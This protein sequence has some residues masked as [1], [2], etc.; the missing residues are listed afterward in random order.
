MMQD[1][2]YAAPQQ[3]ERARRVLDQ[4][5]LERLGHGVKAGVDQHFLQLRKALEVGGV[6]GVD[7]SLRLLDRAPGLSRPDLLPVVAVPTIVGSVLGG[8]RHRRP[9]LHLGIDEAERCGMTP[10]MV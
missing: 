6:D 3:I 8:E 9:Q 7:L 2:E 10:T 5:G 4:I 1:A